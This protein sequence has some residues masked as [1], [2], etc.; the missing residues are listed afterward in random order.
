MSIEAGPVRAGGA[1]GSENAGISSKNVG[2]NPTHRKPQ[3]SWA[4]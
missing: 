1:H 3:V 4:T 2:E